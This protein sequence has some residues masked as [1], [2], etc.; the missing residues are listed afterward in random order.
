MD[1]PCS[2]SFGEADEN[3]TLTV[4]QLR[5][6][7]FNSDRLDTHGPD[8]VDAAD[9]A[10]ISI[11]VTCLG[12]TSVEELFEVLKMEYRDQDMR[13]LADLIAAHLK[14]KLVPARRP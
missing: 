9:E 10:T 14:L 3:R 5:F 13:E 4:S 11:L 8:P 2:T 1:R 7:P 12:M 6:T